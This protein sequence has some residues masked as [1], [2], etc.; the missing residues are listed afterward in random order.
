MSE[1]KRSHVGPRLSQVA[2]YNGV[3]YLA[4]QV[5][6]NVE[7]DM[8]GQTAEILAN[9]DR[10]LAEHGSDKTRLLQVTIYVN[11]M[12]L[13]AGMNAAWE[14]WVVPGHT[15]PRATVEAQL[16]TPQKLV[17]ITVIAAAK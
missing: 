16:A 6:Q 7:Q 3:L 2:E 14:A 13:V 15:P 9:I 5:A 10:L 4:G 17:E 12:A 1:I 8:Q 11:D